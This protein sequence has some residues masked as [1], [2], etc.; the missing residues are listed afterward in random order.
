VPSVSLQVISSQLEKSTRLKSCTSYKSYASMD[1]F[2]R[3]GRFVFCNIFQFHFFVSAWFTYF[4]KVLLFLHFVDKQK[5]CCKGRGN[6]VVV[7]VGVCNF[8]YTI[9]LL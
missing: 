9:L 7:I 8:F 2:G 6:A 5:V 3:I 4:S 1:E